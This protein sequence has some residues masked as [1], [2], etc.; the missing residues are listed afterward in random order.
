MRCRSRQA[1]L[2][3]QKQKLADERRAAEEEAKR[4][5]AGKK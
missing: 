1:E 4:A 3:R 2:M 5:A